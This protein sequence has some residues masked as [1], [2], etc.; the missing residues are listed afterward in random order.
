MLKRQLE[1]VSGFS[2]FGHTKNNTN[3]EKKKI[4]N[5]KMTGIPLG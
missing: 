3:F 4:Q 2:D 5:S 1:K